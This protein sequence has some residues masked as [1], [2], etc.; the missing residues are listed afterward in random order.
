[1]TIPVSTVV[2]VNVII[3]ATFPA[4]A[5]FG[6]LNI[7]TKETG[8]ISAA[9]RIRLYNNIDGV[10][11]DWSA[12]SEPYLAASA[13]FAQQPKPTSLKISLRADTDL[14]GAL[15]TGQV[16]D[17]AANLAA[18][19]T[20]VDGSMTISIDGAEEDITAME[21]NG[22]GVVDMATCAAQLQFELR[23]PQTGGY[24]LCTV[25]YDSVGSK[26]VIRSGTTGALSSVSFGSPVDPAVGTDVSSFFK[27]AETDGASIAGGVVAETIA[28]SL[29]IINEIDP[30]WYGLSFT[31]EVRDNVLVNGSA[32]TTDAANFVESRVKVFGNTSNDVDVLN[33]GSSAD[34]CS[35][36]KAADY[37]RTM[38]SYSSFSNEYPSVS[39][40]G[41]AFTIDFAQPDSTMTLKFKQQPGITVENLSQNQKNVLDGKNGN[42][43]ISVGGNP[44]FAE[45]FMANGVFF[46]EVH[47]VD[48]LTDAAQN[49][50]FGRLYVDP[51]K[52]ANN[53]IGYAQLEDALIG[54]FDEANRNGLIGTGTTI[55]GE[56]LPNG[57]KTIVTPEALI[58][59]SDKA[60]RQYNGLSGVA[61]G[62]G[63]IHGAQINITFER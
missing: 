46:D 13:Y 43:K 20:I 31:K 25:V 16:L 1:M 55:D 17:N 38:T 30:D 24:S 10:A 7:V 19:D 8:V 5:G 6:T 56:F 35:V 63:A 27:V 61:I 57:Y 48:W 39:I 62:S 54:V 42:A 14:A 41:R 32:S 11:E 21:F 9:E 37:K 12:I 53:D 26:F 36:L 29:S 49:A 60:S 40:L 47:G 44:M 28:E 22:G 58:P 50:V 15:F 18:I 4:R 59:E 52:V 45:S 23:K 51:T 33:S 2:T 34:I 3:G